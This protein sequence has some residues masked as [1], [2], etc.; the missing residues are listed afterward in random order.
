MGEVGCRYDFKLSTSPNYMFEVKGLLK[1][2]DNYI[3]V[4]INNIEQE[5]EINVIQN[6]YRLL[7]PTRNIYETIAVNWTLDSSEF[8]TNTKVIISKFNP[9]A[10]RKVFIFRQPY[11]WSCWPTLRIYRIFKHPKF[12]FLI[13]CNSCF[14]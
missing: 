14:H 4:L 10:K 8:L 9:I 2:G 1:R 7:S 13:Y 5:P 3:L 6:P 12:L 11:Y